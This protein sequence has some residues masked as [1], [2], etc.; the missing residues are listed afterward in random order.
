MLS[1]HDTAEFAPPPCFAESPPPP[2]PGWGRGCGY[3]L[4]CGWTFGNDCCSHT[5]Q[6]L[7]HLFGIG[8]SRLR[9]FIRYQWLAALSA[10]VVLTWRGRGTHKHTTRKRETRG[11]GG[12]FHHHGGNKRCSTVLS[13]VVTVDSAET[14]SNIQ[15]TLTP[16]QCVEYH[17][18]RGVHFVCRVFI[19]QGGVES[20]ICP[21][22]LIPPPKDKNE[23][24]AEKGAK[25]NIYHFII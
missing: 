21:R 10:P 11:H 5:A 22:N 6:M 14:R 24:K 9:V 8:C 4:V 7:Y 20:T 2:P 18:G 13:V 16:E 1:L 23:E 25:T 12:H 15:H 17:R 3:M 19:S